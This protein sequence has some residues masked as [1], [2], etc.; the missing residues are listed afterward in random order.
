[1][2][3][4]LQ[5]RRNAKAEFMVALASSLISKPVGRGWSNS[6]TTENATPLRELL[7]EYEVRLK[8]IDDEDITTQRHSPGLTGGD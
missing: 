5:Q 4:R 7:H 1:M 2:E 6:D 8:E 3:S